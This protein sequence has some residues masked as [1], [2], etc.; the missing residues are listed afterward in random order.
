M[1]EPL[2]LCNGVRVQWAQCW[3]CV[4]LGEEM[5]RSPMGICPFAAGVKDRSLME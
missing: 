5:G 2:F 3:G 4:L 1:E